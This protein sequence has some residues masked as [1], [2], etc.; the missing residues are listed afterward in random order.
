MENTDKKEEKLAKQEKTNSITLKKLLKIFIIIFI[1]TMIIIWGFFVYKVIVIKKV[2][3]NNV[4]V[5]LGSNYKIIKTNKFNDGNVQEEILYYKDGIVKYTGSNGKN[6]AIRKGD[7]VYMYSTDQ[8]V[9]Y[10][11]GPET[12]MLYPSEYANL[13]MN[14][15]ISKE[16]VDSYIDIVKFILSTDVNLKAEVVDGK[17]YIVIEDSFNRS[18]DLYINKETY[19]CEMCSDTTQKVEIGTVTDEDMKM[20]WELGYKVEKAQTTVHEQ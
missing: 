7:Y 6:V 18:L 2:T 14:W 17:E 12:A 4:E 5:H 3:D 1:L 8:D 9:C 20:P 16:E 19:L 13:M 15:F 11:I 10:E